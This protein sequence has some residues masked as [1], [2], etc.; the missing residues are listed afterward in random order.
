MNPLPEEK[1]IEAG[2]YVLGVLEGEELRRVEHYGAQEESWHQACLF[3]ESRLAPLVF[4]LPPLA[5]P[6]RLW[7]SIEAKLDEEGAQGSLFGNFFQ[8]LKFWR[9][10]GVMTTVLAMFLAFYVARGL[11]QSPS[12]PAEPMVAWVG[13][14]KQSPLWMLSVHPEK[15]MLKA[16]ALQSMDAPPGKSMELWMLPGEGRAPVSLGLMPRVGEAQWQVSES[17][18]LALNSGMGL[19]VSMEPEGGS[20]TGVPTGPVLYQ[21]QLFS[22]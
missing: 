13:Q 6:R 12:A 8:S 1:W 16:R 4:A 11:W 20:S 7:N 22:L 18:M 9:P 17:V 19:A 2:E 5:P 14:A 10:L 3:W 21:G 15:K